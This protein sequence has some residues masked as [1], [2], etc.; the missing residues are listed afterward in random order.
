MYLTPD[1]LTSVKRILTFWLPGVPAYAFGSRVHGKNLKPRS[2]LDICLKP[3]TQLP[4]ME[5]QR[6]KDAFTLSDLPM[7]V[8][9]LDWNDISA[10]FRK[11]IEPDLT[12]LSP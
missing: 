4:L 1:E 12:P 2:D 5:I 3:D 11:I 8:D 7:R 10:E 6:L 9:V